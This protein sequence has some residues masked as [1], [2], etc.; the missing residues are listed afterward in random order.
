MVSVCTW[1]I[2]IACRHADPDVRT[3]G[4]RLVGR[5]VVAVGANGHSHGHD[6]EELAEHGCAGLGDGRRRFLL[7]ARV[8][9]EEGV[10]ACQVSRTQMWTTLGVVE[11]ERATHGRC[12]QCAIHPTGTGQ[13]ARIQISIRTS[14]Q[15]AVR[16]TAAWVDPTAHQPPLAPTGRA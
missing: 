2:A 13:D 5:V 3:R 14:T 12:A 9:W 4:M 6:D 8:Q 7:D 10:Y 16:G 1:L 15:P 11:E